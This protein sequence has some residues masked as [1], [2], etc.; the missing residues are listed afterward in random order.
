[1]KAAGKTYMYH[2]FESECF[3][4]WGPSVCI[5]SFVVIKRRNEPPNSINTVT[6]TQLSNT[7]GIQPIC[8]KDNCH[9]FW[10][11]RLIKC[12]FSVQME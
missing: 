8:K 1:M 5:R 12:S 11:S 3:P 4:I 9:P 10:H 2:S 6:C 7:K